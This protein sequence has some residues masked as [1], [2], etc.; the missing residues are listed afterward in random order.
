MIVQQAG[1]TDDKC[2]TP[3]YATCPLCAPAPEPGFS[4]CPYLEEKPVEFCAAAPVRKFVTCGERA[5]SRCKTQ[6]HRYCDLFLARAPQRRNTSV[7]A[8]ARLYYSANHMWFDPARDGCWHAGI[9]DLLART[10]GPVEGVT[11][12]ALAGFTRPAAVLH[13]AGVDCEIVF[14]HPLHITGVNQHLRS[15]PALVTSEPYTRGWLFEGREDDLE[16]AMRGLRHGRTV[17][18][19]MIEEMTRIADFAGAGYLADG[20]TPAN[21]LRALERERALQLFH[22]FFSL[23]RVGSGK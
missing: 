21:V 3:G 20:G 2:F 6:A 23:A 22:E 19:W 13:L 9:D 8:P 11:F 14:P 5:F 18:A 4:T 10:L 12:V 17:P 1:A 16:E 15:E 7:F